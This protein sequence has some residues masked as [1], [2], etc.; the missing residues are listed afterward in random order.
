MGALLACRYRPRNL[1]Y[2]E[3]LFGCQEQITGLV[4][5]TRPQVKAAP[6]ARLWLQGLERGRTISG[7]PV[8]GWQ[9]DTQ[10]PVSAAAVAAGL[11]LFPLPGGK[12]ETGKG[13]GRTSP[14][15]KAGSCYRQKKRRGARAFKGGRRRRPPNA[16]PGGRSR[17]AQARSGSLFA[18]WHLP[19]HHEAAAGQGTKG[20]R[21]QRPGEWAG[22]DRRNHT[23]ARPPGNGRL[24]W[25]CFRVVACR[26]RGW[27]LTRPG[28][29]R[30][31]PGGR[32]LRPDQQGRR[33]RCL[34]PLG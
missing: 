17:G 10:P 30:P 18:L 33:L 7:C 29:G 22:P 15:R 25:P 2:T 9:H 32:W 31:L 21:G 28:D 6:P 23:K 24:P 4:C 13:K 11:A 16:P 34:R 26:P 27:P 1:Y 14:T 8:I 19:P 12:G 3:H 5:R 20:D